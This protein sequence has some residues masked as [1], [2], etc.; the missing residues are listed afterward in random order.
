[1]PSAKILEQKQAFVADLAEKIKGSVSGVLVDY[2]GITVEDD[3]K[4][5]AE[6]RK[7]G[8][9]YTVIK[10]TLIS[11]AFDQVGFESSK[12]VLNGMTALALS[13][14]D[15]VAPAKILANYAKDHENFVL[16]AGFVDGNELD[17]KG[18]KA[19]S[20]IPSKEELLAKLLGSM[21]SSLYKFVYG[22]QALVDKKNGGAEE[23]PA[24]AEAAAE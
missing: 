3:T 4:L 22:L 7:A 18:V 11:K 23:A 8:V 14:D 17:E 13:K 24:A 10:N 16:K 1:M 21:Q 5:R 20:E 2:K 9:E 19:L 15:A 12:A 6:L